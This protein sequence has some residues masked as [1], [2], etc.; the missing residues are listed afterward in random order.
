MSGD[1]MITD[2]SPYR[3]YVD[4]FDLTEEEKLELVNAVWMLVDNIYDY[5]LG[6]NQLLLLNKRDKS[7]VDCEVPPVIVDDVTFSNP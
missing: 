6:I 2:L 7:S 1:E 4:Q 5:H 3:Q